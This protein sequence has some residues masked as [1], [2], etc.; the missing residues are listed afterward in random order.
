MRRRSR[1]IR[2]ERGRIRVVI[3]AAVAMMPLLIMAAPAQAAASEIAVVQAVAAMQPVSRKPDAP[4]LA[5][6]DRNEIAG[7]VGLSAGTGM[8]IVASRRRRRVAEASIS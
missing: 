7:W 3:T 5:I 2:S 8:F 1:L 6:K 4:L